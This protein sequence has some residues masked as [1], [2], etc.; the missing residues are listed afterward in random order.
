MQVGSLK[1]ITQETLV[2]IGAFFASIAIVVSVTIWL[3]GLDLRQKITDGNVTDLQA[4]QRNHDAVTQ[5]ALKEIYETRREI[6]IIN[7]TLK[8]MN[9]R[10]ERQGAAIQEI[11]KIVSSRGNHGN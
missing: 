8:F 11:R 2:P 5:S 1:Q 9:D 10:D 6:S 3:T 7:T 4:W